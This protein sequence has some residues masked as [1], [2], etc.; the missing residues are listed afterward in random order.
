MQHNKTNAT[1][2]CLKK[3]LAAERPAASDRAR[4]ALERATRLSTYAILVFSGIW[5]ATSSQYSCLAYLFRS[6]T[7]TV[8]G[9]LCFLFFGPGTSV[10]ET[11]GATESHYSWLEHFS[12][13]WTRPYQGR[14]CFC[15]VFVFLKPVF[16]R[17][18][19][20]TESQC[21]WH[22]HFSGGWTRQCQGRYGFFLCF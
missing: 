9:T 5:E 3:K 19:E 14:Y 21:S 12:R 13:C 7:T 10:V 17:I 1:L 22:D 8:S 20:A 18:W 2:R 4:R 11:L 16:S 6:L 15:L